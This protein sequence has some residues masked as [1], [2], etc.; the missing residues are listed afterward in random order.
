MPKRKNPANIT[1][2]L[3]PDN[4]SFVGK[5]SSLGMQIFI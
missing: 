1:S 4:V 5:V 2:Y 3:I